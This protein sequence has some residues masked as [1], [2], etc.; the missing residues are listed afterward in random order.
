MSTF[1]EKG[2]ALLKSKIFWVALVQLLS[3]VSAGFTKVVIDEATQQQIVN[4]DWNSVWL[5]IASTA[6]ILFRTFTTQHISSLF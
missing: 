4:L 6:I 2:K 5:A 1:D 3:V